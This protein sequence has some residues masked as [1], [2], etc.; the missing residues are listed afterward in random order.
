MVITKVGPL[1]V[2][3]VAA[4]LYAGIGLLIGGLFSLIG[5]AGLTGALSGTEGGAFVGA[6]FGIGAIVVMP[7]CYGL[8]GFVFSFIGAVLFN[9]AVGLTGGIEIETR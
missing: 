1:S 5:M 4:V 2:A 6:L 3:K 7:I 8:L 9:F